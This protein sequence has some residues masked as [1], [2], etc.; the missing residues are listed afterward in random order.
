MPELPE[1]ETYKN[2]LKKLILDKKI[3]RINLQ[4][5][6]ALKT[7]TKTELENN[8]VG[9]KIVRI[10]R[11]AKYLIFEFND[12]HLISHLRMEGKW[13]IYDS[14]SFEKINKNQVIVEIEFENKEIL[15][16]LDFRKFATLDLIKR[17]ELESFFNNKKI[18]PE[19]W[20]LTFEQ[21]K[22]KLNKTKKHIK[23]ILLDQ[24]IISGIGN[25]YADEI[26]YAS[27]IH[28]LRTGD[29]LSDDE[30][31]S[32]LKMSR[33]I[34]EK[35]IQEGGSSIRTYASVNG[36]SGNYQNYLQVHTKEGMV[37]Y[38]QNHFVKKIKVN[39][40]GTYYCEGVQK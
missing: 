35:A 40:R 25:I 11:V 13:N 22:Q 4:T 24:S 6:K 27:K 29:S 18:A 32:I 17:Q 31:L 33:T 14:E 26:L 5:E 38:D 8:L 20:D 30:I 21:F 16:F 37:C 7:S 2:N 9:E 19:P 10:S 34:L 23:T 36:K 39:G 12:Y 28:P 1:V 15:T 3:V